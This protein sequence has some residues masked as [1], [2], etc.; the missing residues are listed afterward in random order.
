VGV[1]TPRVRGT[2]AS[3]FEYLHFQEFESERGTNRGVD[4]RADFS[5]GRIRPYVLGGITNSHERPTAEI[6]ARAERQQSNAAIGVTAATF[7]RTFLS[8]AYGRR[9][10]DYS[11]DETFRGVQLASELNGHSESMT[12]DVAVELTAL[13]TVSAH[14][15]HVQERYDFSSD[16]DA[17]SR[18]YGVTTT[19]N[20]VALIS[21]RATVG[22]RDY[23]PLNPQVRA[24]T[25]VTAAI[26][27]GYALRD[28]T[29]IGLIVDRDLRAS[30]SEETPYYI[31]TGGRVTFTQRL[32]SRVDGHVFAGA[33]RIG[34]E[35]RLDVEPATDQRDRVRT[36]GGGIGFRVG[37]GSR[38]VLNLDHTERSSPVESREYAR[39][40]AY[41]TL[42][43]GF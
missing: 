10:V 21:G 27:L 3:F 36:I 42:N 5:L 29:R 30:F 14:A 31:S 7:S 33:E 6:D 25:G 22:V 17:D 9:E 19:L 43:Y 32:F 8:F 16:R 2:F 37:E 4:G 28:E 12:V 41:V 18:R 1:R 38:L 39:A 15:E 11:D 13:T 24:F 20:P 26:A 34:Y 35:A 40:R 23:R